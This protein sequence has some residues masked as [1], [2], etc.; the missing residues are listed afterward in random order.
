MKEIIIVGLGPGGL[1]HLTLGAWDIISSASQLYLRTSV[2]PAAQELS[3]RG[4]QFTSFDNLYEKG[5][6]FSEVYQ[7]IVRT[8]IA[9]ANTRGTLI[10]AVPGHPLVAEETVQL[11]LKE[12]PLQGIRVKVLS[13]VS[14]LDTTFTLL[15]LDPSAG[16]LLLDTL[17]MQKEELNPRLHTIFTQVYNRL[18]ASDLKLILLEVYPPQ[19]LAVVIKNAGMAGLEEK[20]TVPVAELDHDEYFDHLTSVY[21]SPSISGSQQVAGEYSADPLFGVIRELLS[22]EGCPW[23]REQNHF[24][25]KPCLLEEAYEVIEAIDSGD[26][27]KLAEELGDLLLQVVFH[28]ILAEDR[29]DFTFSE[30]VEGI[31]QKMIRRHPHVFGNITVQDSEEVLRNWEL[32]KSQEKGN[33]VVQ[34]R[35]MD[36]LNRALPALLLAEEVQ[37]KAAKVGFDWDDINGAWDKVFEEIDELKMACQVNNSSIEEEIGDLLFSVVNICRFLKV[38]PECALMNTIQKFLHRFA[39]IE[40]KLWEKGAKWEE[41]DLKSLDI[42]WKESKNVGIR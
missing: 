40:D 3:G 39:Y 11:L 8:L 32:I 1:E 12:A 15:G 25:L 27:G 7:D 21:L 4:V 17:T 37:K 10:Y 14:F 24:T 13:G 30:V 41:M 31:T 2:H 18:V 5:Q 22:P 20:I 16:L 38:S 23:D 9:I 19:H 26:M 6:S 34:S 28:T 42:I 33:I 35:I 36:K 29:G